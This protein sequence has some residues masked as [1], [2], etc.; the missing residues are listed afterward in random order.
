MQLPPE[1]EEDE[2]PLA[3]IAAAGRQVARQC[4]VLIHDVSSG[5]PLP[6]PQYPVGIFEVP[7]PG[8]EG[9][10][11][12]AIVSVL[13]VEGRLLV[14][15]PHKAWNR[16]TKNRVLP[17]TALSKATLVEVPFEDR[18]SEVSDPGRRKIWLGLLASDFERYVN[19]ET[20]VESSTL[21][22]PFASE[23]PFVLPV[24]DSLADHAFQFT[25]FESAASGGAGGETVEQ[26]LGVLEKGLAEIAENL[27]RI[28][29]SSTT[30][31]RPSALRATPKPASKSAKDQT[32]KGPQD[33]QSTPLASRV[34]SF[35][36]EVVR[37]AREAGV[38]DSQIARMLDIA[39]KGKPQLGDVP[40]PRRKVSIL[41]DSEE[42]EDEDAEEEEQASAADGS[43]K[44]LVSAVSK[45][46]K[47][48]AQLASRRKKDRSLEGVLDG[49]GSGASD[50]SGLAGSRR[51]A[52]ALR[53]LRAALVKQPEELYKVLEANLE[54]DFNVVNQVPG[55]AS[56][57]VTARAW[58]EMRSHVQNFQTP[59]R[60]LWGIAGALDCMRQHKH[61]EARARL[62]LM[63]AAGDQLS[64]DRGNWLIAAEMML[65]DGPPL[66]TF[67]QHQLPQEH[68]AP[69]TSLVDGRWVD[70][71]VAKL[72]DYEELAEKKRKLTFKKL[73]VPPI[74]DPAAKA[75]LKGKGKGKGKG[76]GG[77]P[78]SDDPP[79]SQ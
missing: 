73:P 32:G 10:V 67:G 64:I 3:E 51:H 11:L 66:A 57:Q 27:K 68:E 46:T 77:N 61:A 6:D 44:V 74:A 19:F 33:F 60:L 79:A 13:D 1:E 52:A 39:A 72:K 36:L 14:A 55:S 42:E 71:F 29:P 50:S 65:E 35:D 47:I 22:F 20:P 37:S 76:G 17:P 26:R 45:L 30:S 78:G 21:D 28:A 9:P 49:V 70:L 41:S 2:R 40:P 34:E 8:D 54:R 48:A 23:S 7:G 5:H 43:S 53:A 62:G 58:L 56:V 4:T 59:A 15:V 25:P 18:S 31:T 75:N 63:L 69:Y 24:A 38:P 16:T 12:C